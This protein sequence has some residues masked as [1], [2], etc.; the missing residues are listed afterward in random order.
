M[1]P[2]MHTKVVVLHSNKGNRSNDGNTGNTSMKSNKVTMN[3]G[4]ELKSAEQRIARAH[5]I[6]KVERSF[7]NRTPRQPGQWLINSL[8]GSIIVASPK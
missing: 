4:K 6:V 7:Q 2:S 3:N 1:S 8:G 5:S